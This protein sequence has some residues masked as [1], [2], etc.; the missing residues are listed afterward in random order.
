[1]AEDDRVRIALHRFYFGHAGGGD[2][3][4]DLWIGLEALFS[5]ATSEMTYKA[6]MRI[7]HYLGPNPGARRF[8]FAALKKSYEIRSRLVDGVHPGDMGR[9]RLVAS[10]ALRLSLLRILCEGATAPDVAELDRAVAAGS[11]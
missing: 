7:A 2:D 8:L 4:I 3:V 5:D 10:E 9:A 6:A 11:A 1:M